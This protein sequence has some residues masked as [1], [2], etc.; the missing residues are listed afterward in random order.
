[1]AGWAIP[2]AIAG[3]GAMGLAGSI[4]GSRGGSDFGRSLGRE[5]WRYQKDWAT[6]GEQARNMLAYLLGLPVSEDRIKG[7]GLDP[8]KGREQIYDVLQQI[9]GYEFATRGAE[10]AASARGVGVGGRLLSEIA[11]VSGN[12]FQNYLNQLFNVSEQGR[13]A[14]GT[15]MG[16]ATGMQ[17]VLGG[18]AADRSANLWS[19]LAGTGAGLANNLLLWQLMQQ[20][21]GT[22]QNNLWSAYQKSPTPGWSPYGAA[23][24][25]RYQ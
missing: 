15:G 9:P 7:L 1:M 5:G 6:Q 2:A 18:Q 13:G 11:D 17:N 3:A 16:I 12:Q 24:Y 8:T 10:R 19:N 22:G 23:L 20:P 21:Q 4:L 14:A 25:G